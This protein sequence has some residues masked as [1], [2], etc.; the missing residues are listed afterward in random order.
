V[1]EIAAD[2]DDLSSAAYFRQVQNGVYTRMA[3][4]ALVLGVVE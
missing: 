1:D 3:L 2:V 4:I